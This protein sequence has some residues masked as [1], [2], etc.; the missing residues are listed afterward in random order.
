VN[1][2]SDLNNWFVCPQTNPNLETRLFIF[3]YAGG[4]PP[5]FWKWATKFPDHIEAWITHYPGRG[6]RFNE[7]P[8][9]RIDILVERLY[10][11]IQ[12][13]L[14]KPFVFFGHSLGGLVAFELTRILQQNDLPQPIILFV[15][16]CNAPQHPDP[17]PPLHTLPDAKFLMALEEFNGIPVEVLDNRELIKLLLPTLRADFEA[18]EKYRY[19]PN[20]LL[21]DCPIATF[22]GKNDSRLSREDLEGWAAQ[23]SSTFKSKYFSGGHFFIHST[24]DDVMRSIVNEIMPLVTKDQ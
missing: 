3:P 20:E 13:F 1:P 7:P 17:H 2:S 23:T 24:N 16:A 4:S 10:Q 21:I 8:I 14:N 6:S 15:S 9:R 5:A 19:R 12:P 11:A 22:G 18:F